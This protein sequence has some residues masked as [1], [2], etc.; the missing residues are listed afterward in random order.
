M[1]PMSERSL[2]SKLYIKA[3]PGAIALAAGVLLFYWAV[4][5]GEAG[6]GVV[7]CIPFLYGSGPYSFLGIICLIAG[8]MLL[9]TSVPV[10]LYSKRDDVEIRAGSFDGQRV[11]G[12]DGG[13][14]P[15]VESRFKSGGVVFLGP[16]PIVWGSDKSVA[17]WMMKAA[18]VIAA[19][20]VALFLLSIFL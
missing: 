7:I 17:G 15:H 11:Q 3:A 2:P 9:F 13:G 20:L 14:A 12:R 4:R 6:A 1:I 5:T 18:I 10:I 16:I 8:T 19:V